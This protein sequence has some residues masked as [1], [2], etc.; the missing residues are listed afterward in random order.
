MPKFSGPTAAPANVQAPI[1]TTGVPAQT[2]EGG[3]GFLR[4]PKSELFLLAVTNMVGEAT[5]Y[6]ATKERDERFRNLIH[7]VTGADP[8]WVRRFVPYLRDTMQM[9]SASVVMAAEYIAAKGPNG[10]SVVNAAC[11][12]A[13]EPA[14]LL[15]YWA[16]NYGRHFPQPLKRGVAD[17]VKRLYT[18]RSVLRY[19]GQSRSWRMADVVE[20]V[21]PKP[22][23]D[24]QE[25]LFRWLLDKR[26]HGDQK[27]NG[28]LP[29]L[30]A[31]TRLESLAPDQRRAALREDPEA[32]AEA[33]FSWERLSGWLPGGMDAEAWEAVI[34]SMGYMALLRNLRNFDQAGV[35]NGV[36][37]QVAAKLADPE[38]VA[39][40]RQ[41]PI[42]FLSAWK[43]TGSM[44]W[45]MALEQALDASVSN[46]PHLPGRTLI[47]ID[48][49]GSMWAPLSERSQAQRW[50]AA[51]VFGLALAKATEPAD[52]Y[53]YG[54]QHLRVEMPK[55]ASIL[56]AIA[57]LSSL[58]GTDTFG[59]LT[60]TY[61]GHDRVVIL[62][63]EQ[64]HPY[65]GGGYMYDIYGRVVERPAPTFDHIP[66][67][68]TFNLAGYRVAQMEGGQRGRFTFGGLTDAG[69]R[70][71]ELLERGKDGSWSF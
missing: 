28:R 68:Y 14:E 24:V 1:C 54:S 33:G 25:V 44:R 11:S 43:A 8:E 23:D 66:L 40:S 6:E 57:G 22:A 45:G 70:V 56:R 64:A 15:G 59:T 71:M 47:L 13:D 62:T 58:G 29:I 50:E 21:H 49:S 20:L 17:A 55:G 3:A 35:S 41:F 34:P 38:E 53:V 63:D 51:A 37:A 7:E 48:L 36:A 26:H 31:S 61:N 39:R 4:N 2:Y 32:L 9:R 27:P 65:G 46:I 10:R 30:T 69:F 5:F 12:R 42:R 60:Q 16:S 18:Q 19:D 67:I 52:T